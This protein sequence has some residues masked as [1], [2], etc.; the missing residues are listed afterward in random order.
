MKLFI[1]SILASLYC[2]AGIAQADTVLV[3]AATDSVPV[4]NNLTLGVSYSN[5]ASYYGQKAA[6]KIPYAAV[7]ATYKLKCGIYF[8]GL[9]YKLLNDSGA[10]VSAANAGAGIAFSMGKHFSADINYSHTFYPAYSPLLQASNPD[11][12]SASLAYDHWLTTK[13]TVDYAFGKTHDLFG[14]FGTGKQI[15][16]GSISK[17]DV[18]T[19]TPS[20]DIVG[21]TQRF[22]QA[23]LAEKRLRDSLL[24]LITG[25]I[26]GQPPGQETSTK[27]NTSTQFNLLSYNFKCPLD[28][29]RAHYLVEIAYQLSVL[30]NKVQSNAG[31]AN[32]FFSASFYYQ[33]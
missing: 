21:G 2:F 31:Q 24:G 9:A 18:V 8:S 27:T 26:L 23:Y 16:L 17:K 7:A 3:P 20:V 4:K 1:L 13:L 25:P 22:Y 28:Y 29:N 15:T 32:S 14:T 10:T 19:I 12:S 6:T 33:F 11:N 5:N 30:S